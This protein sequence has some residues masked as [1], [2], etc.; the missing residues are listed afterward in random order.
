M[1]ISSDSS[2]SCLRTSPFLNKAYH[3]FG[4]TLVH[5]NNLLPILGKNRH[6]NIE[7]ALRFYPLICTLALAD[8]YEL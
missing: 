7:F 6:T 3:K 1:Y 2:M 8:D 4:K 5:K